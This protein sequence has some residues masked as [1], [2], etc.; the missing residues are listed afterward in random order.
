MVVMLTA[1][2]QVGTG[3]QSSK[4]LEVVDEMRLV[5]E[6]AFED[7]YPTFWCLGCLQLLAQVKGGCSAK[8]G[9]INDLVG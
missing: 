8:H 5:E 4:S 2:R 6:E 7:A 3:S 1:L 9:K